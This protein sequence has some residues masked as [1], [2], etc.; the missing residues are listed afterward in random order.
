MLKIISKIKG[1]EHSFQNF[2]LIS[3]K[4]FNEI[5]IMGQKISG[6]FRVAWSQTTGSDRGKKC[7]RMKNI[8]TYHLYMTIIQF[9][10]LKAVEHQGSMVVEDE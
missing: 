6:I 3:N 9:T 2:Q 4:S 1:C 8:K 7:Y 10:I 5:V